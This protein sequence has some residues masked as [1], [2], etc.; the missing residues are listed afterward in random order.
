MQEATAFITTMEK[1]GSRIDH[2]LSSLHSKQVKQVEENRLKI[3]SIVETI[4]FFC[5]RQ[6]IALRGHRDD[7]PSVEEDPIANHGNFLALLQFRV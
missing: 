6:G 1:K 4:V 5:G 7:R 2:H 3:Q